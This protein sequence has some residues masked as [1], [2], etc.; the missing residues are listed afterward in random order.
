[1][2]LVLRGRAAQS[3]LHPL[4]VCQGLPPLS[5][6]REHLCLWL[7]ARDSTDLAEHGPL[8]GSSSESAAALAHGF[9]GCAGCVVPGHGPEPAQGAQS[10]GNEQ[11]WD[12]RNEEMGDNWICCPF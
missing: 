5:L 6:L 3:L 7:R 10:A 4:R 11:N 1:M 2:P 9:S 12:G 8:S